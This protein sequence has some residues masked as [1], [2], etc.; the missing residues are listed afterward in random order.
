MASCH[1]HQLTTLH[2]KKEEY[3]LKKNKVTIA[4]NKE[5]DKADLARYIRQKPNTG[6]FFGAWKFKLQWKNIWYREK[7]EKPRPAVILDTNTIKRSVKQL[8]IYLQNKGYYNSS[9]TTNVRRTRI[10]GVEAWETKKAV[11]EYLVT[12]G[13][14][15]VIDSTASEVP[16]GSM[17]DVYNGA[18]L[19]SN[20]TLGKH[21]EIET[22]Q[23]ERARVSKE[24]KNNG[25]Y[26]FTDNYIHFDVD[27]NKGDFKT[28]VATVIKQPANENGAH[29][30]Y[31]IRDIYVQTDYDAYQATNEVSD[32]VEYQPHVFFISKGKSKFKPG[33]IFKGIFIKPEECYSINKYKTT[34][35]S[36]VSLHMFGLIDIDFEKVT[37]EDSTE[38]IRDL[39]VFIKLTPSKKMAFSTEVTG[40]Y[41][42]G[43]GANGAI[44]FSNKNPFGGSEIFEFS[45]SGGFENLSAASSKGRII[46]SNIGPRFSLTFPSFLF[47]NKINKNLARNAFPKTT[48]ST[49]FNFQK[50][51]D[52]TRYIS[53]AYLKY[54][55]NEGKYKKHEIH[56][57]DFSF[58]FITKDSPILFKLDSLP[59]SDQFRFQDNISTGVK[60][61]FTYNNQHKPGVKH[62]MYLIAQGSLIGVSSI[63]TEALGVEKRNSSEAISLFDIRYS[64]FFKVDIDYRY[65]LHFTKDNLIAFRVFSGAA[66]IFDEL[67]VVPFEQLYFSGGANSV[68]GWQQRTLGPGVF[69]DAENYFDRLGE[70][71]FETSAE[72]RFPVTKIVKGA[73]FVD[74][75]NIWNFRTEDDPSN[76]SFDSFYE[77]LAVSPGVGVRLDFD[78]FLF[79]VDMAYPLK[80]PHLSGFENIRANTP[81]WNFGIGYPF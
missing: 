22:L 76:F 36:L 40:T 45:I 44:S 21:V 48:V 7:K 11:V 38:T 39:D 75:G 26:D 70:A 18:L 31:Y 15:F 67:S 74:A 16:S 34:Y 27:T 13:K 2:L 56:V 20:V 59:L 42:E 32:T 53:N 41:R 6:Y 77:Q 33:P 61:K 51:L 60:Y 49:L 28:T 80:E 71:K 10:F 52:F 4:D 9:I 43:F 58:S 19:S 1:K 8:S 47:F 37:P 72:Y 30:R 54:E 66:L 65:Y 24:F 3:L 57:L 79:R 78:F 50:R 69:E 17:N 81:N 35:K 62:P 55:W 29:Y 23:K 73:V 14:P 46:G 25:Y 68:R 12:T 64:N 63:I 5:L